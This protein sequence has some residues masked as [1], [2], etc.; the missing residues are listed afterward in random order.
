MPQITCPNCGTTIS[1]ENRREVD[2]SLIKNATDRRPRTF[3]ELLHITRLSRKT[4][5]NRLKE[6][7]AEGI[8]LKQEGMYKLNGASECGN[9]GEHFMK[10]LS[11]VFEDK[12]LRTGMIL[13]AVLA[14]FSVSGYVLAN[15]MAPNNYV[16]PKLNPIALGTFTIALNVNNVTDLYAWQ[17]AI[18]FNSA[19]MRVIETSPGN[20]MSVTF[21]YFDSSGP[22]DGLQLVAATLKGNATG[23]TGTG[24]LATIVFEYYVTGYTPPSIV[25]E[26]AGFN[27]LL[28]DSSLAAIPGGQSLLALTPLN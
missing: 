7:C 25:S 3:T 2:F 15:I 16:Q 12:R 26:K 14:S 18:A 6:L 22:S 24:T 27:T 28:E 19:Q 13:I 20:L 10:G 23:I 11:R 4:L 8:L 17:A 9:N 1:L 5:N 21:P